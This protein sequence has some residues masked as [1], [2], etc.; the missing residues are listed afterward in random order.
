M[1]K[2]YCINKNPFMDSIKNQINT[3][4]DMIVAGY[5]NY[6]M[7]IEKEIDAAMIIIDIDPFSSNKALKVL[8]GL[9]KSN[10]KIIA[11]MNNPWEHDVIELIE[12]GVGSLI[13]KTEKNKAGIT[14]ML[15][16]IIKGHFVLPA[17]CTQHFIS[18][19]IEAS[20]TNQEIF[21]Y[22]LDRNNCKLTPKESDIVYLMKLGLRNKEIARLKNVKE[23][24]VKVHISSIYAK[25]G[26]KGRKKVI[27]QLDNMVL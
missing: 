1:I 19:L 14:E 4:S 12:A 27:K 10:R 24:T 22:K 18:E 11:V 2:V 17:E 25:L 5:S 23:G 20:N 21:A 8:K 13:I 3:Q 9:K 26:I 16:A 6:T 7:A 15:R